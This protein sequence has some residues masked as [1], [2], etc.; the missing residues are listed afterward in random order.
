VSLISQLF[1]SIILTPT[2]DNASK[3]V[4]TIKLYGISIFDIVAI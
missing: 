1:A 4:G 2:V 3:A